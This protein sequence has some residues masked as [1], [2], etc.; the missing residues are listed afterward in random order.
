VRILAFDAGTKRIGVAV[1]DPSLTFA[2]GVGYVEN[3]EKLPD[4]LK[5]LMEEYKPEKIVIGK[6]LNMDGSKN[7]KS[8]FVEEFIEKLKPVSLETEIVMW[9]ERLTS[10]QANKM[11]I[12]GNV[13]RD[14]RKELVDK[15]AAVLILQNYLDFLKMRGANGR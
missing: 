15:V 4:E 13:R 10:M 8:T 5:K 3:N 6:P 1:S 12:A 7:Q 9:D 14:K 2:T 11:L